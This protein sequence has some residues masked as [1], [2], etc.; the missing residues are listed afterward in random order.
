MTPMVIEPATFKL[1]AQCL[2]Q[3][4]YQQ[5]APYI[6]TNMLEKV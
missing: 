1:V 3:L 4:R 6:K 5:R 2:N